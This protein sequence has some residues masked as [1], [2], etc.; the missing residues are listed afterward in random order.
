MPVIELR[1]PETRAEFGLLMETVSIPCQS[2][3]ATPTIRSRG[4]TMDLIIAA[5]QEYGPMTRAQIAKHLGRAKTPWLISI[6]EDLCSVGL[7]R[8]GY[9]TTRNGLTAIL[10]GVE[11]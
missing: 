2:A 8:R 4:E 1:D 6:C 7:I 11:L 3:S 9:T 10:Y 5:L